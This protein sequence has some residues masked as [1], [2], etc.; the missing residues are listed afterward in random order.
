MK[1]LYILAFMMTTYKSIGQQNTPR[2]V[3]QELHFWAAKIDFWEKVDHQTETNHWEDSLQ[4]AN[5][6][7]GKKLKYYTENYPSTINYPFKSLEKN[8]SIYTADNGLFR[9]YNWDTGI[10]GIISNMGNLFQYKIGEKTKSKLILG[11]QD[12]N[13]MNDYFAIYHI[14]INKQPYYLLASSFSYSHGENG[15]SEGIRAFTIKNGEL[16]QNA[17]IIKTTTGLRNELFY[18]Y[19]P[20]EITYE[21]NNW[22]VF[23]NPATKTISLPV[24]LKN[25]TVT[26]KRIVYK[27]TGQYFEKLKN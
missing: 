10:G 18:S 6:T 14:D 11:E 12:A 8:I 26:K 25:G 13:N 4:N 7:F 19:T 20:G 22:S 2:N 1:R 21:N 23:Y 15:H 16:D 5:Q 17:K 24:V 27:F 3:E 9:I